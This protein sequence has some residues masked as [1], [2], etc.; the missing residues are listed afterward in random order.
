[1]KSLINGWPIPKTSQAFMA[2]TR[3]S[4]FLIEAAESEGRG[5]QSL[6][7]NQKQG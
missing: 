6:A 5:R 3:T 2:L 4:G 1:M 7:E